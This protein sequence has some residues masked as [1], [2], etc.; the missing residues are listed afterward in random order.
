MRSFILLT[1]FLVAASAHA[2]HLNCYSKYFNGE[3]ANVQLS[4][5]IRSENRLAVFTLTLDDQMVRK[6]KVFK[7]R[8]YEGRKYTDMTAFYINDLDG[9]PEA[10]VE[11]GAYGEYEFELLLPHGYSNYEVNERFDGVLIF[12]GDGEVPGSYNKVLCQIDE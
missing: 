11:T 10:G 5:T 4:A 3:D 7:G 6:A 12:H 1:T 9:N 8:K 2:N